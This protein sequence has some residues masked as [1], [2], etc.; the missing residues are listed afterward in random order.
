MCFLREQKHLISQ[1][2]GDI[3]MKEFVRYGARAWTELRESL[4]H[5]YV[6]MAE[7]DR[8]RYDRDKYSFVNGGVHG[9]L[10]LQL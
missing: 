5:P 6:L 8:V 10:D 3:V 4:K 1:E 2:H 7:V 9:P